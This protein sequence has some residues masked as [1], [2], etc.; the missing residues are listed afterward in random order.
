MTTHKLKTWP[1]AFHAMWEG[2]K[3]FELRRDDRGFKVGDTLLLQEWDPTRRSG[4]TGAW[5]RAEVTFVLSAGVFPGLEEGF[6]VMS[7]LVIGKGQ[8]MCF[9]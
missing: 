5:L 2:L 7:V 6:V 1:D 4:Y 3:V 9:K 8:A